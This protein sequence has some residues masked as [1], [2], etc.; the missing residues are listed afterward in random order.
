MWTS[1]SDSRATSAAVI[2][3]RST[4][5]PVRYVICTITALIVHRARNYWL[6]G[7]YSLYLLGQTERRRRTNS[8]M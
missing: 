7:R 1:E 4:F 6:V 2:L 3:V 5:P 8:V